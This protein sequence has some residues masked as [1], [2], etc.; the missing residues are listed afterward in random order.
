MCSTYMWNKEQGNSCTILP[1]DMDVSHI[2]QGHKCHSLA[3]GKF[4]GAKMG[5]FPFW[6]HV[7]IF[8]VLRYLLLNLYVFVQVLDSDIP[9]RVQPGLGFDQDNRRVQ[10]CGCSARLWEASKTPWHLNH[11]RHQDNTL[12]ETIHQIS[13]NK[14]HIFQKHATSFWIDSIYCL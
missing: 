1:L 6:Y 4:M 3:H 10:R 14:C 2:S 7:T 9:C 8:P 13:I 5:C 11:V 12:V